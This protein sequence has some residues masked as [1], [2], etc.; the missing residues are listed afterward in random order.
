MNILETIIEYKK[1]EVESQ[2]LAVSE[3]LLQKSG[4]FSRK[5]LSL[6]KRL[7]D[8]SG[9]GIIA[10]FKRKSPSKGII[11]DKADLAAVT[12]EYTNGASGLSILT[13]QKFFGG[14]TQDILRIRNYNIPI[15]RK[16]F[17]IDEYQ[18]VE[19]RS[20]GADVILLIAACLSPL[21]VRQLASFAKKLELEVLLELH[22]D[23]ELEHI[24][25][26]VDM[27]GINNRDLKTFQVDINRSIGLI[28]KIG[29]GKPVVA[30]SGISEVETI[31][32]LRGFGFR[33][34]LIGENFMKEPDPAI[35]FASF[36]NKL[37]IAASPIGSM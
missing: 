12:K 13:D 10:E 17:M 32:R 36:I 18:I 2:K 29:T 19:A 16:D 20:I 7:Q 30:E 34:F 21:R 14:S 4:Y 11:N 27:I 15:L 24:C 22:D 8:G 5:P 3:S 31:A 1:R 9:N 26:E 6:G 23:N 28:S 35:A 25:D 33:G 37:K